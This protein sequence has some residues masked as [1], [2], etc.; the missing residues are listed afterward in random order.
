MLVAAVQ[1]NVTEQVKFCD[2]GR[3]SVGTIREWTR[4]PRRL[5]IALWPSARLH[6]KGRTRRYMHDGLFVRQRTATTAQLVRSK[7]VSFVWALLWMLVF[8]I[9]IV[10][11]L[12][13]YA[14]K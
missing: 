12:I 1:I 6:S 3:R 4:G 7:R 5:V 8:G 13:Y 9:G 2:V 14:A 10:V 11:S